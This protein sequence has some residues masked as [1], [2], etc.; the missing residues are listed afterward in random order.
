MVKTKRILTR[1]EEE[2]KKRLQLEKDAKRKR[3]ERSKHTET[4]KNSSKT[5]T[6]EVIEML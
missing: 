1:A 3:L 4:E 6:M 5:F 2:D